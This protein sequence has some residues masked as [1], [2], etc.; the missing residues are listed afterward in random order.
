MSST[1][2]IRETVHIPWEFHSKFSVDAGN[3]CLEESLNRRRRLNL[4]YTDSKAAVT[5]P[6]AI[7]LNAPVP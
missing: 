3:C 5:T 2:C 1:V 7:V 4:E 6:F